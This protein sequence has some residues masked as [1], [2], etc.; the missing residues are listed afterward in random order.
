[1][2]DEAKQQ[3]EAFIEILETRYGLNP[4]DISGVLDQLLQLQKRAEFARKMG[5]FTAKAI[6]TVLV[7]AF[8]SG[9]AWSVNQFIHWTASGS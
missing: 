1:M 4:D 6:I 2:D 8:F 7:A 5:E 9:L 3:V